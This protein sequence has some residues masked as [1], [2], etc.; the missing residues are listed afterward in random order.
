M[1]RNR[2]LS[3][4]MKKYFWGILFPMSVSPLIIC[5]IYLFV[6]YYYYY[7][8]CYHH[9]H[10]SLLFWKHAVCSSPDVRLLCLVVRFRR[11][12]VVVEALCYISAASIFS[13]EFLSCSAGFMFRAAEIKSFGKAG[14][15]WYVSHVFCRRFVQSRSWCVWCVYLWPDHTHNKLPLYYYLVIIM[16]LLYYSLKWNSTVHDFGNNSLPQPTYHGITRPVP[17]LDFCTST[18]ISVLF[19]NRAWN[20]RSIDWLSRLIINPILIKKCHSITT[21]II[22]GHCHWEGHGNAICY[23][24]HLKS[25]ELHLWIDFINPLSCKTLSCFFC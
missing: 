13:R 18:F 3:G 16:I 2:W 24:H 25:W 23:H 10:H 11:G 4:L 17:S 12:G 20:R 8:Y 6:Y 9:H 14:T 22:N 21:S 7:Y 5:F 19:N 15:G 1:E